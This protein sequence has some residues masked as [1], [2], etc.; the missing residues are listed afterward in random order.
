MNYTSRTRNNI[1]LI[2]KS[3]RRFKTWARPI[4]VNT[5]NREIKRA[6][7]ANRQPMMKNWDELDF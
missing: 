7:I 2:N 5:V 1:R 4:A 3:I 6:K